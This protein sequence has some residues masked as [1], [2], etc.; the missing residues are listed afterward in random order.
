MCQLAFIV[1]FI[2]SYSSNTQ[3]QYV[4]A[5]YTHGVVHCTTTQVSPIFQFIELTFFF[6]ETNKSFI[7]IVCY[8]VVLW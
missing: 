8:I 6:K 2:K 7:F 5:Q 3:M 1:S 4:S